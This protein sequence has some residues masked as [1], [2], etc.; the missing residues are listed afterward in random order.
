MATAGYL[1][2]SAR[3]REKMREAMGEE[4]GEEMQSRC[5]MDEFGIVYPRRQAHMLLGRG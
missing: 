4:M 3:A 2:R 1:T 5:R